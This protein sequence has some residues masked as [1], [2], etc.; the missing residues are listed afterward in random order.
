MDTHTSHKL[1]VHSF[2][3]PQYLET[4]F[5]FPL[6]ICLRA[7]FA[8]FKELMIR[9]AFRWLLKSGQSW[10]T[11]VSI[12]WMVCSITRRRSSSLISPNSNREVCVIL[13]PPLPFFLVQAS[14]HRGNNSKDALECSLRLPLLVFGVPM[15]WNSASSWP[16]PTMWGLEWSVFVSS[17]L[18]KRSYHICIS[19]WKGRAKLSS[20]CVA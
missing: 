15:H 14:S 11:I 18:G 19:H 1:S 13:T 5:I 20:V 8:R 3:S 4:V 16:F 10:R 9:S 6:W 12:P 7:S 2:S 17:C